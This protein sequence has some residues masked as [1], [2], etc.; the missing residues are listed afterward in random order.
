ME[1]VQEPEAVQQER[2]L[3]QAA[4]QQVQG[5][6]QWEREADLMEPELVVDQLV[7]VQWVPAQAGVL[8]QVQLLTVLLPDNKFNLISANRAYHILIRQVS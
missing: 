3:V 6:A 4:D 5:P 1:P 8:A 2:A 7:Q